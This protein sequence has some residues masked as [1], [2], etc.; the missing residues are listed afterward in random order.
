MFLKR[1]I[2]KW[3]I[4]VGCQLFIGVNLIGQEQKTTQQVNVDFPCCTNNEDGLEIHPIDEDFDSKPGRILISK[5]QSFD[6]Y[7]TK[8]QTENGQVRIR[9]YVPE[10][11]E[12][13]TI[14]FKVVDPD[15]DDLSSYTDID[16]GQNRQDDIN[17]GDN[18][19]QVIGSGSLSSNQVT[20]ETLDP[21]NNMYYAEVL[22]NITG[23]CSG[24]NYQVQASC[25][26]NFEDFVETSILV[27]WKRV[28]FEKDRMYESGAYLVQPAGDNNSATDDEIIVNDARYFNE[29]DKVIIFDKNGE[30][31]AKTIIGKNGNI[32]TISSLERI[33]DKYGGVRIEGS[34]DA[35]DVDTGTE[36]LTFAFGADTDGSDGGAFVEF[37]PTALNGSGFIPYNTDLKD[38]NFDSETDN[39]IV[40]WFDNYN[41]SANVV[42]VAAVWR[43]INVDPDDYED[44]FGVSIPE[45]NYSL[46]AVEEHNVPPGVTYVPFI[47]NTFVH[48][49]GHQFNR[50]DNIDHVDLEV[51]IPIHDGNQPQNDFCI[52]S[53][54]S[55]ERD[56]IFEFDF[57]H[58]NP[59]QSCIGAIRCSLDPL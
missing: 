8:Y 45:S 3:M 50:I 14:Y 23:N 53:A 24:D 22:L 1:S 27:A 43:I 13:S 47:E 48:E 36:G 37:Y 35:F 46:I 10:S 56:D 54:V 57:D 17:T 20:A 28:Y 16:D 59:D 2:L 7:Y 33:F 38:P 26:E 44:I 55:N 9:A 11:K 12:G 32:L 25:D 51:E 40:Y 15:L 6:E 30:S 29:M 39:F 4:L 34:N 18:L 19:D 42:Q 49:I 52:M 58:S 41:E 5:Q 21:D 31:E